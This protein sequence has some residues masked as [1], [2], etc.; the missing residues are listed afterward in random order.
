[1]TY[2]LSLLED[3]CAGYIQLS[4]HRSR[5]LGAVLDNAMAAMKTHLA[6]HLF[7]TAST[8]IRQEMIDR[9]LSG[10]FPSKKHTN[11]YETA[12]DAAGIFGTDADTKAVEEIR[13]SGIKCNSLCCTGAY[14][15]ETMFAI[16]VNEDVRELKFD[17][18]RGSSNDANAKLQLLDK[19]RILR[20]YVSFQVPA[21]LAHYAKSL[22]ATCGFKTAK[23]ERLI[24]QR[25]DIPSRSFA[26]KNHH[27]EFLTS[28]VETLEYLEVPGIISKAALGE[29]LGAY[30]EHLM[31]VVS[32]LFMFRDSFSRLTEI[33]LGRE[34]CNTAIEM[35]NKQGRNVATEIF[36]GIGHSCPN[37]KVLD[38]SGVISLSAEC[39]LFLFFHDLYQTLHQFVYLPEHYT[40]FGDSYNQSPECSLEKIYAHDLTTYCPWCLDDWCSNFLKGGSE[41]TDIQVTV[42]DDRMYERVE[43]EH[44]DY[45]KKFLVNVIKAS[46]LVKSMDAPK[47]ILTR[48]EGPCPWDADFVD[49]DGNTAKDSSYPWY[50]P[51]VVAYR[52]L[53]PN[54]PVPTVNDITK[55]L[56]CLKLNVDTLWPKHEI[57]PFLLAAMPNAKSLGHIN[58]LRGLKMIRDIPA[59]NGISASKLEEGRHLPNQK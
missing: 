26:M 28:Y 27:F 19:D 40:T 30:Q 9:V 32:E 57:V 48:P 58:V 6:Q 56:Q 10:D 21:V 34:A 1:M 43:K 50:P 53:C 11:K 47:Y 31:L 15:V 55:S 45:A 23:L 33:V 22:Q 36:R 8:V 25:T 7:G 46:D 42:I 41:F 37:L 3:V 17:L 49:K 18:K 2:Y 38:V 20:K 29:Q 51:D 12:E 35:K 54:N 13:Q 52:K 5:V 4:R 39:L 24:I 14:I 59:L 16:L 44:G